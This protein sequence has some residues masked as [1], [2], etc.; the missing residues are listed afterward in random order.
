MYSLLLSHRDR[1]SYNSGGAG[2]RSGG[3]DGVVNSRRRRLSAGR[4][5]SNSRVITRTRRGEKVLRMTHR[6]GIFADLEITDV[7]L[8]VN[9]V[10]SRK[11]VE[12][13]LKVWPGIVGIIWRIE[14]KFCLDCE[15]DE[16]G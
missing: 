15:I 8:V 14:V 13:G 6:L 7:N 11:G 4:E 16:E 12:K 9:G 1:L 2:N 5:D 10:S 3:G